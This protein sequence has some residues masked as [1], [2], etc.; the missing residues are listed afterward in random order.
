MYSACTQFVYDEARDESDLVI[1]DTSDFEGE[2]VATVAL[3]QSL[4]PLFHGTWSEEV[5]A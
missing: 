3:G 2:P 5:Y 4:P 1:L